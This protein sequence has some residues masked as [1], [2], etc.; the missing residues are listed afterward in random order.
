LGRISIFCLAN[1]AQIWSF[2]QNRADARA[3]NRM[4]VSDQDSD[5]IR[6]HFL[7]DSLSA[8]ALGIMFT[9]LF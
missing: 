9:I 6:F 2:L 7:T 4:V 1:H 3:G 5:E 8:H